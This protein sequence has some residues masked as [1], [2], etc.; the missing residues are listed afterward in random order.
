MSDLKI[1]G[2]LWTFLA[3]KSRLIECLCFHQLNYIFIRLSDKKGL[4][5][6]LVF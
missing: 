5:F 3:L 1:L 6:L 2:D 4:Y